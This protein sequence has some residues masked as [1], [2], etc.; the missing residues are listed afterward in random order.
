MDTTT[1]KGTNR[2]GGPCSATPQ[3]GKTW[4]VWHDPG[5][6]E[7][8]KQWNRDAGR[9]KSN[10]NRARKKLSEAVM[11]IDDIDAALCAAMQQVGSGT[12]EPGIGTAMATIA[13]TV[14]GI[15]TA[16]EIERRLTDLEERAGTV[17]R[18]GA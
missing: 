1:C 3:T 4:C 7:Q 5:L 9:A 13:K 10:K 14:I 12:M 6:V 16:S 18:F 11:T 17:R 2:A 15:R 8:R